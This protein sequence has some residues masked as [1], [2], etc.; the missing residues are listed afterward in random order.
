MVWLVVAANPSEKWW[1]ESQLGLWHSQYMK[2]R[3]IHVPKHQPAMSCNILHPSNK[4]GWH[5]RVTHLWFPLQ[6]PLPNESQCSSTSDSC[7]CEEKRMG[8]EVFSNMSAVKSPI[9]RRH[10]QWENHH[11]M[12]I[13]QWNPSVWGL[14]FGYLPVLWICQKSWVGNR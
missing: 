4:L 12:E 3:K 6:H 10:F 5:R 8:Q 7:T 2:S 11:Y 1:S 9:C 13:F 14:S